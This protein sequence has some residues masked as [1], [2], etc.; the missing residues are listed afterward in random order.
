MPKQENANSLCNYY[1][2]ADL[3]IWIGFDKIVANQTSD[4]SKKLKQC[5]VTRR[6]MTL[7]DGKMKTTKSKM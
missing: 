1:C 3:Y 5:D 7:Y 4:E 6:N 2:T